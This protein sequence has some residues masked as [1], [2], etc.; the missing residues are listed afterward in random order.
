V[1]V[2]EQGRPDRPPRGGRWA[3]VAAL[4]L[5]AGLAGVAVVRDAR[6]PAARPSPSEAPTPVPTDDGTAYLPDV[7]VDGTIVAVPSPLRLP[8]LTERTGLY[9]AYSGDRL[10]VVGLDG[11][12][13]STV[14]IADIGVASVTPVVR[15]AGGWLVSIARTC[16]AFPCPEPKA[17]V[18]GGGRVTPVGVG[19]D[20]RA[21]PD[22]ATFWITGYTDHSAGAT[23][24]TEVVWLEHRTATGRVL[25]PRTLLRP[26]ETLAGVTP[27]GPVVADSFSPE[28]TTTLVRA[29][30]RTRRVLDRNGTV[31]GVAGRLVV[32]GGGGCADESGAY[33]CVLRL[34][35]VRTGR[36]RRE[37]Q[38]SFDG[39]VA[40]N[41]VDPTGRYLAVTTDV[42]EGKPQ[43][44]VADLRT[45]RVT[46][47]KGIPFPP[48]LTALTWSP[49]GRWLVLVTDATN[50]VSHEAHTVSVWRPGWTG[51]RRSIEYAG[52]FG[53][54]FA[55][56]AAR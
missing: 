28:A 14:R 2:V 51:P 19:H 29:T 20:A 17:Y 27:E 23:A 30:S 32:I 8:P 53:G 48:Y 35:D 34:V 3:G 36:V 15:L 4:L 22:G 13:K 31:Y 47:L 9:A 10:T 18:A 25:G 42:P 7:P 49:D 46:V 24:E 39:A 26:G 50:D 37:V 38:V 21:D 16:G 54:G 6:R 56:A 43:V 52:E 5:V 33:P 55:V 41:A 44:R 12:A 40:D 1:D 11:G 45:G